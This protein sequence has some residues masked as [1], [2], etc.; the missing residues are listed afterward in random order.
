MGILTELTEVSGTGMDVL[1]NS[2]K[3][4]A[5]TKMLYPYPGYVARAYRAYRSSGYGYECRTDLTEVPGTGMNDLHN[6]QKCIL[7]NTTLDI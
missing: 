6:V 4:R 3:L 2:Q 5:G 1:Q 7:Q